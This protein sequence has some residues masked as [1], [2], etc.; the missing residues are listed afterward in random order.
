M[1]FTTGIYST[2][3]ENEKLIDEIKHKILISFKVSPN[4]EK[5]PFFSFKWSLPVRFQLK[6]KH[7]S[8]F[9]LIPLKFIDIHMFYSAS[10]TSVTS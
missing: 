2:R 3:I 10:R 7:V 6:A 5:F 4:L 9:S 8:S 1:C